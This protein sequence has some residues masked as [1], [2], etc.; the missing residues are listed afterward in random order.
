MEKIAIGVPYEISIEPSIDIGKF[1]AEL[2]L[3]KTGFRV[4]ITLK[5]VKGGNNDYTFMIP[6]NLKDLLKKAQVKY[7]IFVYKENAR[8]EVDDDTI[9]FI[10]EKDFKVR[11]KDNAKM[12]PVE[13]DKPEE[14][15]EVKKP[16]KKSKPKVTPEPSKIVEDL[17]PEDLAQRLIDSNF[18]SIM[19]RESSEV[20]PKSTPLPKTGSTPAP[21]FSR[22]E[23]NLGSILSEIEE[24]KKVRLEKERVNK[25]IRKALHKKD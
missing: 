13:E 11:V 15:K 4:G 5:K 17:N 18:E 1:D 20:T 23:K 2:V 3:N 21:T 9:K 16:A 7:S 10:D 22:S 8:F 12:R 14:E 19:N 6:I 25:N 24:R